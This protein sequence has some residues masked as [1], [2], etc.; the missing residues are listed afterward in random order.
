MSGSD[1]S[2]KDKTRK[3]TLII[4]GA[5][6]VGTVF[7]LPRFV[8]DP[9]VAGD[10]DQLPVVPEASP[11]DVAPSTAAELTQYRQDSQGVL[12][13]IVLLRDSLREQNVDRW[14]ALEFQQALDQVVEGDRNY[15]YGDYADSLKQ[16]RQALASLTEIEQLGQQKLAGAKAEAATAIEELNVVVA[17]AATDLAALIAPGDPEVQALV[18]RAGNLEV[19][20]SHVVNGDDAMARDRFGDAVAEYRQAVELDPEHERAAR[21]LSQARS[22]AGDSTYRGH[23]S[24]GFAALENK[25][26]EGARAAFQR[27][28][29]MRPGDAAVARA[30]AQV[31][32]RKN[33]SY[34]SLE[35]DRAASLEANEQWAEAETI[36]QTLLESDPSLTEARV[37]LI[38]VQVRAR[39]D[40]RLD[41][42]IEDPLALSNKETFFAAR[43]SLGDARGIPNPGPKLSGQIERLDELLGVANSAVDV[44]FRSDNQTHVVLFRVAELGR[45]EQVSLK[46]RPGKYVAAGTRA[47]FRDVRVEFT[48]IG[49]SRAEPVEVRCEEPVG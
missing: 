1:Q 38:P 18:A 16:F 5:V 22:A 47:G 3:V 9:W 2:R 17:T 4:L 20:A 40:E 41:G 13:E 33:A 28:G 25:D 7:L 39:L 29:Q 14:A 35:L 6:V 21:S 27:A 8:T 12:S 30:L 10:P 26:Y 49:G 44:V 48:V 24:R 32:N 15:S 37:R 23:M 46:L 11:S 36:Y 19:L 45:F 31:D 42:Y 34:V 43:S